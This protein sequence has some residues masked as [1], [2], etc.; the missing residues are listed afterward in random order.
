[1]PERHDPPHTMFHVMADG[2]EVPVLETIQYVGRDVDGVERWTLDI[3]ADGF[4]AAQS[5][6]HDLYSPEKI[7]EVVTAP[8]PKPTT[9]QEAFEAGYRRGANAMAD[10]YEDEEEEDGD[11]NT[12]ADS[13]ELW[14]SE[15]LS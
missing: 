2:S 9:H 15:R 11:E 3:N 5:S 4:V 6:L 10:V 12:A 7:V 1:M 14:L 13:F 8:K